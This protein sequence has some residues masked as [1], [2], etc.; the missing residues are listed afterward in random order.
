MDK[1][2]NWS[3]VSRMITKGN[4]GCIRSERLTKKYIK[5]LDKLFLEQIP[6]WWMKYKSE[7]H[8]DG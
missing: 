1:L 3:E 2:I 8:A 5:E 6:E 7:Q 4:R